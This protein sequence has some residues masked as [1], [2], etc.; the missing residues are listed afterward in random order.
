MSSNHLSGVY[1][2]NRNDTDTIEPT[3]NENRGEPDIGYEFHRAA[4]PSGTSDGVMAIRIT[5]EGADR[6]LDVTVVNND[7]IPDKTVEQRKEIIRAISK[8]FDLKVNEQSDNHA[9]RYRSAV[10][11]S[12]RLCSAYAELLTWRKLGGGR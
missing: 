6:H 1:N 7:F 9:D 5:V 4:L 11:A 10:H 2:M 12:L 8:A 3:D